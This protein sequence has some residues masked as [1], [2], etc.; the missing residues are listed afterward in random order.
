[1]GNPWLT[2]LAHGFW[3]PLHIYAAGASLWETDITQPAP[4]LSWRKIPIVDF[5]KHPIKFGTIYHVVAV[6]QRGVLVLACDFGVFW[7]K[8]P[9]PGGDYLF[10]PAAG[11]PGNRYSGL[12]EG[13]GTAIVAGAWG[14]D[15]SA[16]FGIFRGTWSTAG[17]TFKRSKIAGGIDKRMLRTE[18]AAFPGLRQFLYAIC[19]DS[20]LM[21]PVVD[22]GAV[23]FD[24][25]GNIKWQDPGDQDPILSV[26]KSAD[27]GVTW[28]PTGSTITGKPDPL[29]PATAGQ[30][31]WAGVGQDGYNV[32]IGV[33][34]FDHQILAVGMNNFF[35][36]VDSGDNWQMFRQED[37]IP[38]IH[39]DIHGLFFDQTDASRLY[40]CSDGGL[41][42]T[43]DLGDHWQS[44]GNRQLPNM[45]GS[46]FA[47]S[48]HDSGVMAW[49]LQDNGNT[50]TS[51]YIDAKPWTIGEGGD[52]RVS[53]MLNSGH[54]VRT[55]NDEDADG[56][57]GAKI[58]VGQAAHAAAW[59]P[60]R[61]TF[62]VVNIFPDAPLSAGVIPVDGTDRGLVTGVLEAVVAPAF[63]NGDGEPMVAVGA[64]GEMV[65]GMFA[66]GD[67][68]FHWQQLA[69]V[70]HKPD[71]DA[72]GKEKP[73]SVNA[74][75]SLDGNAVVA[76]TNNGKIF[77]L[78]APGWDVTDHPTLASRR[79]LYASRLPPR[80]C[81]T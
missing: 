6:G 30:T 51:L 32:C 79:R 71:L 50:Y 44:L 11:L 68:K 55:N 39:P 77:R 4:L 53:M 78:D 38:H 72:D 69:A 59:D 29:F 70:P 80:I 54:L 49:S 40:V 12:A 63:A 74:V 17:L 37:G 15:G 48:P 27:G 73:Y 31:N 66:T 16:H 52:G 65:L 10:Q 21:S 13:P 67:G 8:I 76:G 47:A 61:R 7:A 35:V 57:G 1:M 45:Q 20:S 81:C 34:P 46:R 33:S 75:A 22:K 24:T 58:P 28:T 2:C 56:P 14:S 5:N 41:A 26:L 18:I 62:Q 23:Q 64:A 9:P 3:G 25:F 42:L 60:G 36:S 43:T 19:A